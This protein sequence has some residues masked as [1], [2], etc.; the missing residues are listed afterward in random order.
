MVMV[1]FGGMG[2]PENNIPELVK[3]VEDR[4]FA[5]YLMIG[6]DIHGKFNKYFGFNTGT[7]TKQSLFQLGRS[8]ISRHI[9]RNVHVEVVN[10]FIDI[11]GYDDMTNRDLFVALT[12]CLL[13]SQSRH[14][15]YLSTTSKKKVIKEDLLDLHSF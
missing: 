1:Y 7:T 3:Y 13:A 5:G 2:Y 4:K 8:F 6:T 12:G 10:E 9:Q 14:R 15:E 11:K